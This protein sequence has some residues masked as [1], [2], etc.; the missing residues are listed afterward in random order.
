MG[1]PSARVSRAWKAHVRHFKAFR[2]AHRMSATRHTLAKAARSQLRVLVE[3][4]LR[5]PR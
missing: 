3:Y 5:Q 2:E 4:E 1:S